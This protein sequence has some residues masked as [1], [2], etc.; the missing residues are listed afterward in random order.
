[1]TEPVSLALIPTPLRPDGDA[2]EWR[3]TDGGLSA[4]A[5][6]ATD[7]FVDP[8]GDPPTLNAPRLLT[9]LPDGD[10][11]LSARVDVRFGATF[12]AGVLLL[13]ADEATW[14]KLCFEYS[15]RGRPMVVSVIT[16]GTS[17]DANGPEVGADHVWLRVSRQQGAFAF[18]ASTD[19]KT[20]F[21]VRHFSLG[22]ARLEIGFEVQSPT[23]SGC[24]VTFSEITWQAHGL[25][26]L[27]DG[28]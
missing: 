13:W 6:A 14:G 9:P 5:P 20:W 25:A 24:A 22:G 27:R 17:D 23:G 4:T 8:A 18:H 21:F 11:Q 15:P 19:G 7:L 3:R 10:F 16:R 2:T 1:M 12:D 26:D 28:T